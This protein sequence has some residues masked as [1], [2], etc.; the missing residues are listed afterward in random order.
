[1]SKTY[2]L[3]VLVCVKTH[4]DTHNTEL[5]ADSLACKSVG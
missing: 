1:M 5:I 2:L 3:F 4:H